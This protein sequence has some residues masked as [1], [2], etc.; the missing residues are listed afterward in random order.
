MTDS[1]T[2]CKRRRLVE[3]ALSYHRLNKHS[4]HNKVKTKTEVV[5]EADRNTVWRLFNSPDELHRWQPTLKSITQRSGTPAETGE[6][7][8]LVY[9]EKGREVTITQT[10]IERRDPDFVAAV[11]VSRWG[12]AL[13]VNHF[14]VIDDNTTQWMAYANHTFTGMMR[15]GGLFVGKSIRERAAAD[16]NKFKLV[17]ETEVAENR[18]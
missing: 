6:V 8:E 1:P 15:L 13:I 7:S 3:R 17:V 11:Y 4:V 16:M 2:S 12:K 18:R 14:E 10:I 5:I 9:V